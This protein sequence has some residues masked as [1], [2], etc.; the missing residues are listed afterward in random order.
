MA[1]PRA[2][3][4]ELGSS[5]PRRT[6]VSGGLGQIWPRLLRRSVS[7]IAFVFEFRYSG[8][9]EVGDDVFGLAGAELDGICLAARRIVAAER[10]RDHV[11]PGG[12]GEAIDRRAADRLAVEQH[13]A[14][15]D[16]ADGQ[17]G[18]V[19]AAHGLGDDSA[20]A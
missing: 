6:A 20:G 15:G 2:T 17:E 18:G 3:V 5:G 10:D 19:M 14:P 7:L 8:S 9:R 12:D 13:G 11:A 1:A 4:Q 16:R